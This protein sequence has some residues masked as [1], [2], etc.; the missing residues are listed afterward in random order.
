MQQAASL[1][2]GKGKGKSSAAKGKGTGKGSNG[3]GHGHGDWDCTEV[4]C[5]AT[6]FKLGWHTHCATRRTARGRKRLL[7]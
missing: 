7:G 1:S 5:D 4:G 6:A 2:K 3:C